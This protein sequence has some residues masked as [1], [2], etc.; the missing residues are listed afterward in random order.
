MLFRRR[1]EPDPDA[2]LRAV[3]DDLPRSG[4]FA[5]PLRVE[6]ITVAEPEAL[7]ADTRRVT[8]T[9]LVRDADG[10][11]CPDLA[12]EARI[13]GPERTADGTGNTDLMGRV[14]FRM[15]GPP[16]RYELTV[17][18]VAAGALA[19]DADASQLDAVADA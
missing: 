18:D 15:S 11:R 17:L 19:F 6:R 3:P 12:V 2:V 1:R 8:F 13:A 16:G 9:V 5:E 10:K 4:L 14:R 7:D